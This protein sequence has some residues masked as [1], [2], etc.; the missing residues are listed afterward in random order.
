[1]LDQ[2]ILQQV[3]DIFQQLEAVYTFRISYDPERKESA[4]LIEFL[5]DLVTSSPQLHCEFAEVRTGALEFSIL[6]D[7]TETGIV[8]RGIPNGHEF[9]SLLLAILSYN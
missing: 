7:G 3:K 2:S 5:N 6:K 8:F 4:Q 9:T 1:M